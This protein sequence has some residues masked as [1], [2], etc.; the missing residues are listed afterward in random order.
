MHKKANLI[1][2]SIYRMAII[3]ASL[4]AR[5]PWI[6]QAELEGKGGP[7]KGYQ[8]VMCLEVNG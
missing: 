1:Q 5:H 3:R 6:D 2:F 7:G 8:D 4:Y